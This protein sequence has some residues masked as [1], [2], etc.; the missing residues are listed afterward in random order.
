MDCHIT[1][2]KFWIYLHITWT[3]FLEEDFNNDNTVSTDCNWLIPPILQFR[4]L[5]CNL[6]YE[7]KII[8]YIPTLIITEF[9]NYLTII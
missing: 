1:F 7:F 9:G 5:A 6:D 8:F 3:N 2:N 4:K